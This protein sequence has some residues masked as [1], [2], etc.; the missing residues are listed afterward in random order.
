MTPISLGK[1]IK[2]LELEPQDNDVVFDFGGFTPDLLASYRGD[3]SQLAI[4]YRQNIDDMKVSELL[5]KLKEA[6]GKTFVGYKG[7][8]YKMD[9]DTLIWAANTGETPHTAITGIANCTWKTVL[10][11]E[12]C[13]I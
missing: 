10:T 8:D 2:L 9:T 13:D 5:G 11:T 12:F 3:Y 4:S 7:G 1:L 6:V